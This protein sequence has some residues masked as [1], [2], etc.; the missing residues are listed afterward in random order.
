MLT[1]VDSN[2]L[3][4]DTKCARFAD[5]ISNALSLK[6]CY[7]I[8]KLCVLGSVSNR[9]ALIQEKKYQW[10]PT[11]SKFLPETMMTQFDDSSIPSV[12]QPVE[13]GKVLLI[14]SGS[15]SCILSDWASTVSTS[16]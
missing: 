6:M 5:G 13:Q 14:K 2:P 16:Q 12:I 11:G 9:S 1:Y 7:V 15:F 3:T 8:N 10:H 4:H